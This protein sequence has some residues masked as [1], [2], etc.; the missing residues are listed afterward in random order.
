MLRVLRF[1]AIAS[2]A[3]GTVV[4]GASAAGAAQ[5]WQPRPHICAGTLTKPGVLAGTF[6]G[7]VIVVGA[8]AVNGGA[9]VIRD[10][11][12]LTPG[13]VLDA[14]FAFN[15]VTGKG[16]SSLTVF[17]D[18]RVGSG[19]V[20]AIGCEPNEEPCSDDPNATKGGTLTGDNHVFGS[21]SA[22]H[23][24]AVLLHASTVYGGVSSVGG[25]GGVTC[26]VPKTGIFHLLKSPVFS[27]AEDN[28]VGGSISF[29]G[30][31]TCWL[32][33]LRNNVGG[34]V[35]DVGNRMADPDA[36]EVLA[37]VIR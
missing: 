26:A 9:A 24:L 35:I 2:L 13:S 14:T 33:A 21:I 36:N 6:H 16:T 32:G 28:N 19:A 1:A 17:G 22:W 37:N 25:G 5:A 7:D 31:R 3:L 4:A 8:C 11:L 27:D 18:V 20:V 15:D 30:L 34:S 10:D 29:V 23:A 12:I